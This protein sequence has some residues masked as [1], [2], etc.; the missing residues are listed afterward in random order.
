M[1]INRMFETVYLLLNRKSMTA[2]ELADHFGVSQRTVY[3]DIDALSQAGIPVYA[4]K[5]RGGGISLMDRFVLNRS[6]FSKEEQE[7]ILTALQ[8]MAA[9]QLPTESPVL[10]KLT[11]FFGT[12]QANWVEVD[13]SDWSYTKQKELALIKA[14]ILNKQRIAFTY[15]NAAGETSTRRVEPLQL[16]FKSRA[17]YLR[18][19][20]LDRDAPRIFKLSRMRGVRSLEEGF[21]RS[22]PLEEA[23]AY[24]AP[25]KPVAH[26]EMRIHPSMAYRVYDE[27]AEEHIKKD[28]EGYFLVS[29]WFPEDE[30]VYGTLLSY[31]SALE[32][33]YPP[34][35]R[36]ILRQRM[37][38][39]LQYYR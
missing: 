14:S 28:E 19:F 39:A 15:H 35:I 8:G 20:C 29:A 11:A 9:L 1:Q 18:A 38:E 25:E 17:W 7:E 34:H 23:P 5:G 26:L 37:E 22:Y 30:W 10:Q 33:L 16:W 6:V 31:G 21:Q 24:V 2:R 36:N 12:Q 27:F 32:L 3:R 4:S 13:F